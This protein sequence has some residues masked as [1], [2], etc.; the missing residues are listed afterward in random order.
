MPISKE[1]V[2]KYLE[3]SLLQ[4]AGEAYIHGASD[5]T[6][7]GRVTEVWKYGSNDELHPF[8]R[9]EAIQGA[10]TAVLPGYSRLVQRQGDELFAKY[11]IIDHHANDATGFTA[12]LFRHRESG[13]YTAQANG[14]TRKQMAAKA[15]GFLVR[16]RAVGSR[17]SEMT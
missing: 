5:F 3:F 1:D 9:G 6:D 7:A 12:T 2:A 4:I 17:G 16:P 15:R 8:I 14:G 13:E 11:Q 10:D